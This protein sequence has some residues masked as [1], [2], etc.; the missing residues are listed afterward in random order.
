MDVPSTRFGSLE[1]QEDSVVDLGPGLLGFADA[2]RFAI[3]DVEGDDTYVWL[4]SIEH[5]EL[6]FLAT[7]P[8][9][10]FPNYELDVPDETLEEIGLAEPGDSLVL[11]LLTT[12][13][14][15]DELLEVTAN[16][17]GPVVVNTQT[18]KGRQIVLA[19]D[20]YGTR[21]PLVGT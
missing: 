19:G 13:H 16:L 10:F 4:Q 21:E 2:R 12:H 14:D 1:I 6:A 17:L 5:S 11:V 8:W 20:V 15:G 7:Q 3:V 18:L 9:S